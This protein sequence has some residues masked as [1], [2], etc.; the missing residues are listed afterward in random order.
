VPPKIK[1]PLVSASGSGTY[2]CCFVTL[3]A[4]LNFA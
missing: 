4:R 3:T 2:D 1:N